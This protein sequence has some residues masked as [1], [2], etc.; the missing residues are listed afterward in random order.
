[1]F[2]VFV[3]F[4]WGLITVAV[5]PGGLEPVLKMLGGVLASMALFVFLLILSLIKVAKRQPA[6]AKRI[7]MNGPRQVGVGLLATLVTTIG[8]KSTVGYEP[9]DLVNSLLWGLTVLAYGWDG[10]MVARKG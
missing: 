7:I 1:M 10:W 9:I 2:Y 3:A 8:L 5:A 4:I 6:A